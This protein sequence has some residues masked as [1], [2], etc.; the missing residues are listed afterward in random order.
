MFQRRESVFTS[1]GNV[2]QTARRGST[3]APEEADD[4]VPA[5]AAAPAAEPPKRKPIQSCPSEE[6]M[7][8]LARKD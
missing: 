2:P 6:I 8:I 5:L 3:F 1:P 7:K 4:A